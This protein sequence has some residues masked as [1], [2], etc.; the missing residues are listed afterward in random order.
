MLEGKRRW[1]Y[2]LW[3]VTAVSVVDSFASGGMSVNA[4]V[5][6]L[7]ATTVYIGGDSYVKGKRAEKE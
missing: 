5:V 7:G 6:L 4:Q 1:L 3:L 2:M